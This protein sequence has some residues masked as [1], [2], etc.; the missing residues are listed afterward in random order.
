MLGDMKE[1]KSPSGSPGSYPEP[2]SEASPE[3]SLGVLTVRDPQAA[4]ALTDPR[5]LRQL[6]PFL[7]R[8]A[9][10][11][12]AARETGTKPN[13]M[14]SRVR[15]FLKLGLLAVAAERPRA[16]R[17]VKLYRSVADAFF[18]PFDATSAESLEAALAERDAY[19][20]TLLR[21]S[22]VRART[23]A[24]ESWGTRV[25]RDARGRLQ[26]QT[27][28]TAERNFTTLDADGPA[29]LSAWRD[30]VYLD[31]SDA[32]ALQRELFDLLLRYQRKQGAQRYIV[33]VAMAPLFGE[34][35]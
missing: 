30:R 17:R 29:V 33:R 31:F 9:T 34:G 19:W 8:A 7:A 15:R 3:P 35:P 18:I 2:S 14:L 11:S 13:T 27:A 1:K 4:A 26:V 28:V 20:E 25:Y 10:V 22:V 23:E 16:G 12:E 24:A 32:K 6:E 21:G 5:T